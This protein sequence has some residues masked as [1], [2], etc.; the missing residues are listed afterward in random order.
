[1][2]IIIIGAGKV[3]YTLAESLS[4]ENHDVTV[5]DKRADVLEK[6]DNNLDVMCIRGNG[7]STTVLHEA[8]IEDTDILI[9]VTESDE[10]NMVC[11]LTGRTL[12]AKNT[13]AR[14][15]DPEYAKELSLLKEQMGLSLVINPE[16]AAADEI[17]NSISFSSAVNVEHF[18]KGLV[19][20]VDLKV[21]SD[22]NM[23]GKTIKK[24]D[25]ET[26]SSVLIGVVVRGD[27][28][29]VPN[30]DFILEENDEI[31]VI[32]KYSKVFKFCKFYNKQP[33]KMKK[34]MITGGGR[35]GYY[36]SKLLSDMGVKVKL[37]EFNKEIAEELSEL[38]PEVLVI[39]GD[40]TDDEVLESEGLSEMDA[41]ISVTGMDEENLMSALLAKKKGVKKVITKISRSNYIHIVKDLGLDTVI[42][43]KTIIVNEILKYIK[44]KNLDKF[45]KIIDGHAE[46]AE[47][48]VKTDTL[49]SKPLRSLNINPN[50]IIATIVRRNEIVVP[51]GDDYLKKG[52]TI[53][54]ISMNKSISSLED[55]FI[56]NGGGIQNELVNGI[57]KLGSIINM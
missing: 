12:G 33:M 11:C 32:G 13:I 48:T 20:M 30:G 9:A 42:V 44:G 51:H 53:V 46:I 25:R 1:M 2:K 26:N 31:Y 5:I 49:A 14:I 8:M 52:D 54:V 17:A 23:A 18:A 55:L 24:I 35:I 19:R 57:K 56:N 10:I 28:V 50:V 38:L 4:K 45:M 40:G 16:Q 15:R 37:I 6:V 27:K 41:F 43:P 22:M 39:H 36:L 29:F 47:L 3:G 21:T 7:V 34:V